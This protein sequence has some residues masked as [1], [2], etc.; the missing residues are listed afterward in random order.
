MRGALRFR[1]RELGDAEELSTLCDQ[2][3]KLKREAYE[4]SYN[5][6]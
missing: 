4:D 5:F 6:V 1:V 2:V 3:N